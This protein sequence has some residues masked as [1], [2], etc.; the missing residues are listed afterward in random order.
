MGEVEAKTY[1]NDTGRLDGWWLELQRTNKEDFAPVSIES[2]IELF[3]SD[4]GART[5]SSP[6]YFQLHDDETREYSPVAGGCNFGDHC[7]FFYSEKEDPITELIVAQYNVAFTYK[8]AF[9][10]I[11]AR[12]LEFDMD[13]DYV[14]GAA[15]TVLAKLESAPTE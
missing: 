7:E 5:A 11:M 6:D 10:W 13:A 12:G 3:E 8:N 4:K 9:V 14:L 15:S 2:S 1:V